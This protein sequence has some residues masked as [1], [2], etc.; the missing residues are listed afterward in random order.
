MPFPTHARISRS[1]IEFIMS[2]AARW[3]S[4]T[5]GCSTGPSQP[6]TA[7]AGPRAL[8]NR[9][10]RVD[11]WIMAP[12]TVTSMHT[13]SRPYLIVSIAPMQS[14]RTAPYGPSRS[15]QVKTGDFLRDECSGQPLAGQ[16]RC[17]A[18]PN[19]RIPAGVAA[20]VR[21]RPFPYGLQPA[22]L[23]PRVAG[24]GASL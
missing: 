6:S 15:E 3:T 7:V 8:K 4:P 22:V 14:K 1:S 18:R 11:K 23:I 20:Q 2:A 10:V 9:S 17:R 13:H 24:S 21:R 5:L 12:G 16:A 19:G